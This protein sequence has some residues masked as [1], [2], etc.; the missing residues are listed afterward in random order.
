MCGSRYD[1]YLEWSNV[2]D[3]EKVCS[4]RVQLVLCASNVLGNLV[5]DV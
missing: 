3:W 1:T 2:V 5:V 4:F